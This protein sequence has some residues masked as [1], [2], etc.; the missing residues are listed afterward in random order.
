MFFDDR[1]DDKQPQ[2]GSPPFPFAGDKG[3]ENPVF[4]FQRDVWTVVP[5][6]HS[7]FPAVKGFGRN[8]DPAGSP[9][10][11]HKLWVSF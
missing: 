5:H 10:L 1:L 7:D 6:F 3:F 2:P 11:G 9:V 4:Q 8:L